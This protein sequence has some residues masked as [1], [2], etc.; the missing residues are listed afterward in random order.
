[1]DKFLDRGCSVSAEKVNTEEP[2]VKKTKLRKF[3]MCRVMVGEEA[4]NKIKFIPLS[5]DTVSRRIK[6]I[7][8]DV[9]SQLTERLRSCEQF[10]LQLDECTDVVVLRRY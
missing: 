3:D 10:A 4:A 2:N 7:S 6:D 1:M 9:K 8:F 5:N